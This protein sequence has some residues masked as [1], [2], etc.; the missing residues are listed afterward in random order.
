MEVILPDSFEEKPRIVC[1]NSPVA[2]SQIR[3]SASLLAATKAPSAVKVIA[4]I[5]LLKPPVSIVSSGTLGS[6]SH[7]VAAEPASVALA[8]GAD[9]IGCDRS[10]SAGGNCT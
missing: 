5:S 9:T 2:I 7:A 6:E 1:I 4:R 10:T 8:G 3:I